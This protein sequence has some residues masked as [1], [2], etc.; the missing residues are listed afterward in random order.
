LVV[1][2]IDWDAAGR[3]R[4]DWQALTVGASVEGASAGYVWYEGLRQAF[5]AAGDT[6]ILI[7]EDDRGLAAV[8]PLHFERRRVAQLIPCRRLTDAAAW[9]RP[10]NGL[11]CRSDPFVTT[12]Q[13]LSFALDNLDEWDELAVWDVLAGSPSH[14]ALVQ[15]ARSLELPCHEVPGYRSPHITL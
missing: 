13:M 10:H 15:A 4:D 12:R 11:L 1:T 3:R 9:F 8:W 2:R 7:A 14:E 6:P 5:S